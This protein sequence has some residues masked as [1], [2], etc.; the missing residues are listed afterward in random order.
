M[1]QVKETSKRRYVLLV[2]DEEGIRHLLE[3][4]FLAMGWQV[5]VAGTGRHA[6][7]KISSGKTYDL[8]LCDYQMPSL[9]GVKFLE[10]I[11][12]QGNQ[13]PLIMITGHPE[14]NWLK[15]AGRLKLSGVLLKPFTHSEL[16]EKMRSVLGDEVAID[17][18]S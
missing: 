10:M 13:T 8:I 9:S 14:A 6:L 5:D 1:S 11:R 2:D 7:T 4:R 15:K 16:V 17:L 12:E 18:A 3:K